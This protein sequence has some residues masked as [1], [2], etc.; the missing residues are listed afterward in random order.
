M[1]VEVIYDIVEQVVIDKDSSI[2][3]L[4]LAVN[5]S[6][7]GKNVSYQVGWMHCGQSYTA[8]VDEWRLIPWEG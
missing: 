7:V 2:V 6:G 3:G 1:K 8:W 5:V 4:I